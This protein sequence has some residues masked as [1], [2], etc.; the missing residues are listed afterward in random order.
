MRLYAHKNAA[1]EWEAR[2]RVWYCPLPMF[3]FIN[4]YSNSPGYAVGISHGRKVFACEDDALTAL[5]RW[6]SEYPDGD[7]FMAVVDNY[8]VLAAVVTA[9]VLVASLVYAAIMRFIL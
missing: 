8:C 2:I 6:R 5:K 7:L 1:T 3:L 9:A 4:A